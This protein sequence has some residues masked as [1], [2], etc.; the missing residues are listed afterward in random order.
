MLELAASEHLLVFPVFVVS[1]CLC[2]KRLADDEDSKLGF[3]Q[4]NIRRARLELSP[5]PGL[6]AV[7][8]DYLPWMS[9][10]SLLCFV[11]FGVLC[12]STVIVNRTILS[13]IVQ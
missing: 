4:K 6:R 1:R 12:V 2:L 11:E 10:A 8:V 9:E 3:S 13:V 5:S 7:A